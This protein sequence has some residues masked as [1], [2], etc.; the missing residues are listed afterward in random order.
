MIRPPARAPRHPDATVV[1]AEG[2]PDLVAG[3]HVPQ[4]HGAVAVAGDEGLAV[5]AERHRPDRAAVAGEGVADL[6]AGG[7]I[8]E[9]DGAIVAAAG[10]RPS[11]WAERHRVARA[12]LGCTEGDHLAW[13]S[14]PPAPKR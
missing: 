11:A 13:A 8:P 7:H 4:S 2:V 5:R 12:A 14:R 1:V 9:P 6:E 3:G 10:Q